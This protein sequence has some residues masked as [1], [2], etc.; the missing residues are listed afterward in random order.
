MEAD[1]DGVTQAWADAEAGLPDGWHLD[2]LR[3]AS[4]GLAPDLRSEEW[5][6]VALGPDGVEQR[7]RAS[8]PISALAGLVSLFDA[9]G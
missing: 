8:E 4:A 1:A 5:I 2:G 3:C 7:H 6:A 9:D